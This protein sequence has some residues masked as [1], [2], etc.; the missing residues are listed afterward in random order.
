MAMDECWFC[1][2][3]VRHPGDF[4]TQPRAPLTLLC[5]S[6]HALHFDLFALEYTFPVPFAPFKGVLIIIEGL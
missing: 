3:S 2:W 4:A 5:P 6:F 1:R